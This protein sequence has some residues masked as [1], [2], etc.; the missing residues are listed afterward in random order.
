MISNDTLAC[1]AMTV[2]VLLLLRALR[3]PERLAPH[4]ALGAAV[5]VAIF[6]KYTA[7]AVI[8]ALVAGFGT[9]LVA[10][11]RVHRRRRLVAALLAVAIPVAALGAYALHNRHRYGSALP[12]PVAQDDFSKTQPRA[13]SG[14][15]FVTFKPW[16][17]AGEPILTPRNLDSFWTLIHGRMWFDVEPKFVYFTDGDPAWW[18]RY[19]DWLRGAAPFPA[20]PIPLGP[21]TRAVAGLLIGAGL[22]PLAFGVHGATRLARKPTDAPVV[23]ALAALLAANTAGIVGLAVRLPVYSVMKAT[24]FL[25]SLPALLVFLGAGLEPAMRSPRARRAVRSVFAV[26]FATSAIHVS[27][28]VRALLGD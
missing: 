9:A 2:C 16:V 14:I 8:P 13:P 26:L 7:F 10:G 15:G 21:F 18:M 5:T 23:F 17:L 19:Y 12:W 22:I 3:Q 4:L 25:G 27:A 20:D 28:I 6:T 1:L 11:P 24:F